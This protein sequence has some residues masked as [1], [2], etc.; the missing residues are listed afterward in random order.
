MRWYFCSLV[1]T[2][3][4]GGPAVI[5]QNIGL[6]WFTLGG[7]LDSGWSCQVIVCAPR[8]QNFS[9]IAEIGALCMEQ[10][11]RGYAIQKMNPRLWNQMIRFL[12]HFDT[13]ISVC[14]SSF[15]VLEMVSRCRGMCSLTILTSK[16]SPEAPWVMEWTEWTKI[17][18]FLKLVGLPQN[19]SESF[20]I[21]PYSVPT[22]FGGP[23]TPRTP[24]R[25]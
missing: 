4:G 25:D 15:R 13:V 22:K 11:F 20:G 3:R 16:L 6:G 23:S 8:A 2:C 14:L 9:E 21:D 17:K 7:N 5:L 12:R 18:F 24:T 19:R 1:I 10:L